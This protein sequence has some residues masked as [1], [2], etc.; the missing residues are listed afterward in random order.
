[1]LYIS[2]VPAG[3]GGWIPLVYRDKLSSSVLQLVEIDKILKG[4]IDGTMA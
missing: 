4:A 1:M 2:A 3:L